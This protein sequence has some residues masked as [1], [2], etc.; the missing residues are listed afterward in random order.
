[1]VVTARGAPTEVGG[2][3]DAIASPVYSTVVGLVM[4]GAGSPALMEK[5]AVPTFL[6]GKVGVKMK[7]WFSELF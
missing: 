4:Y 7:S 3:A 5:L 2:M 6:L 1:M